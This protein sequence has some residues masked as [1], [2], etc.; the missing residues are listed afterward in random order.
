MKIQTKF[1]GEQEIVKEEIIKFDHGI[2]GFL[3]EKEFYI[4]PLEDTPF[5]ILQSINTK[6]V[7]FIIADPF[8]LF[9]DYEFDLSE[10]VIEALKIE[11]EKDVA[12]FVILTVREP[13]N[14][15]T[16]NLQAPVIINQNKKLGKQHILNDSN[17]SIRHFIIKPPTA[18]KQEVK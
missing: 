2:P 3:D 12:V 8:S 15:T 6:E 9:P 4:F 5:L 14:Q 17:Y 18:Q 16:A 10:D 1:H 11:A 13:F 7:A